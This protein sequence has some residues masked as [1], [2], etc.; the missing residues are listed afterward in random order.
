MRRDVFQAIAD[1]TRRAIIGMLAHK[2]LNVNDVAGQFA[3]SRPAISKHMKIL[4]ECGLVTIKRRGRENYCQA[5]FGK[6]KEV[7]DWT[8]RYQK[9]WTEKLDALGAFLDLESEQNDQKE[10]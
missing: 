3:I 1:P 5:D 2:A 4:T 8:A 10:M 6:L 9:F 7:A